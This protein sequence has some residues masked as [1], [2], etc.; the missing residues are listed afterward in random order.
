[1]NKFT[2]LALL[3][4]ASI[5]SAVPAFAAGTDPISTMLAS[6]DLTTVAVSVAAIGLLVI[7]VAMAF[8]GVD[9]GKRAVRKV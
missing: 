5:G 2:K 1:M 8:K 9:L 4:V 7:G 3:A 6:I